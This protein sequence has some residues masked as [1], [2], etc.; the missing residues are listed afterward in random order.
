MSSISHLPGGRSKSAGVEVAGRRTRLAHKGRRLLSDTEDILGRTG[1]DRSDVSERLEVIAAQVDVVTMDVVD[2]L[3]ADEPDF[4]TTG[5]SLG[6]LGAALVALQEYRAEVSHHV[7]HT[8]LDRLEALDAGLAPLRRIHDPEE[9]LDRVSESVVVSCGFD[10]AMISRVQD[11]RWRPWKGYSASDS[12]LDRTFSDWMRSAPDIPLDHLLLESEMVRR[13]G[14]TIVTDPTT[15]SRVYRPMVEASGLRP[16]VAAPLMPTGRVIGFLHADYQDAAVE[17][18]DRDILWAFAEA[19][20]YIF[21]RAVLLTRLHEQRE[22]VRSAVQTV[23]LALEDLAFAEIELSGVGHD[24]SAVGAARLARPASP[25][26]PF[27]SLLTPR[28]YEVLSLMATGATNS[29]IAEQL[30]I[31]D[32]TVKSHVKQI[33]R[34]LRSSNRAEAIVRFLRATAETS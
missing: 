3:G 11:S 10:R 25:A 29:R 1:H 31:T 33:L 5:A 7:I 2:L 24:Q 16:Y 15:D 17:D 9:L 13:R 22:R 34:K 30:V 23:E 19:F 26:M 27:A 21:E 14:P 8:R 6:R 32:G 12:P 28:E 20:G 4:R 18:L